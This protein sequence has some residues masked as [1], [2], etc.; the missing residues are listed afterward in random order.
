MNLQKIKN[1]KT[2]KGYALWQWMFILLIAAFVL[3]LLFRTIPLYAENQYIVAGLKDL[4]KVDDNLSEMTDAEIR[5]RMD[6]Y[7]LI[8][9][10][11]SQKASDIEIE[12]ED[13]HVVVKIDYEAKANLFTDQPLLGT[14][15][16]VITFKNHLDSERPRECC[17]PLEAK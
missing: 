17:K 8:N 9:N 7:Y 12:R 13:N 2:Q 16:I 15:D 11:R 5:K 14:V 6:N 1:L 4:V 3:L 10:V